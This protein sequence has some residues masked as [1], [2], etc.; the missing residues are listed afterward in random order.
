MANPW[1]L[2]TILISFFV[3]LLA[4]PKWIKEAHKNG[5]VGKDMQKLDKREVAEAGGV[6]VLLGT[7]LG[8]LAYIGINTFVFKE[9][10]STLEDIFALLSVLLISAGV[11]L[12]DDLLGWKKGLSK[13]IRIF[14]ILFA[15]VPLMV[16]NAGNSIIAGINLG[17]LYPLLIIP[18]GVVG[19]TT[20]FNFLEGYNGLGARQGIIMLSALAFVTYLSGFG[21]LSLI[22]LIMAASLIAFYLFN[23]YPAKVFP[24]DVLT[25]SIG[26]MIAAVAILGNVEKI[27]VLFFI[28]YLLEI[29]LKVRGKLTKE[30]FAKLNEDGSLD[31]PYKKIYSLTHMSIAI[32]K[33]IKP[34]HKVY[35]KDVVNLINIFQI[36]VIALVLIFTYL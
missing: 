19:A 30:S 3:T 1:L 32:L 20:T 23:K 11:G 29:A 7:A 8:I 10:G 17:I 12:I 33:K 27:A 24:G 18:I 22:C 4:L 31:L 26:A 5:L 25:Y 13:K 16:I 28:P 35:E 14:I 21:W 9:S 6:I 2:G 36:L 15:A 34:S